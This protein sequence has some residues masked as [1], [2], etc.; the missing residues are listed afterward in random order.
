MLPVAPKS[1]PTP[2][3]FLLPS[4]WSSDSSV[5]SSLPVTSF[6]IPYIEAAT[7]AAIAAFLPNPD[8]T[9]VPALLP[10]RPLNIFIIPPPASNPPTV[11]TAVLTALFPPPKR[12][13]ALDI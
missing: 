2:Y 1:P 4:P 11:P 8:L 6:T 12:V 3:T 13:S 10:K 9:A 7:A 5:S